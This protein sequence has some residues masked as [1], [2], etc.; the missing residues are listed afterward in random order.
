MKIDQTNALQQLKLSMS[1]YDGPTKSKIISLS[2]TARDFFHLLEI[3][4]KNKNVENFVNVWL[5]KNPIK[6]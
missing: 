5:L 6:K 2:E 1:G 4:G 3:F